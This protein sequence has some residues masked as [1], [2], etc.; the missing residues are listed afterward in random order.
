MKLCKSVNCGGPAV[1]EDLCGYCYNAYADEEKQRK[2]RF[3]QTPAQ[4][5][6]AKEHMKELDEFAVDQMIDLERWFKEFGEDEMPAKFMN[7]ALVRYLDW[8]TEEWGEPDAYI[9]EESRLLPN[10]AR[11]MSEKLKSLEGEL[12]NEGTHVWKFIGMK[13]YKRDGPQNH[14]ACVPVNKEREP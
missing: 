12:V 6:A 9:I 14:F 8:N 4:I 3:K 5:R 11:I 13:H 2:E 7:P 1:K 10:E